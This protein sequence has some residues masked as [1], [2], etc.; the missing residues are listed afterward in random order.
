MHLI[1]P[2]DVCKLRVPVCDHTGL[3]VSVYVCACVQASVSVYV[4]MHLC[5][6]STHIDVGLMNRVL[7]A[8]IH[9]QTPHLLE[10]WCLVVAS[11]EGGYL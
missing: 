3:H 10:Q 6:Y 1:P 7:V 4:Q 5:K 8:Q 9:M 2:E 11:M